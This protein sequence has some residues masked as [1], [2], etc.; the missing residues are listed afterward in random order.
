V[1]NSR[2]SGWKKPKNKGFTAE[3]PEDAEKN[4]KGKTQKNQ[5]G[6]SEIG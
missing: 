5:C 6:V 1:G 4:E 2:I 3:N